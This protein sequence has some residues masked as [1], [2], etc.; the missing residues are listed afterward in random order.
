LWAYLQVHYFVSADQHNIH[1]LTIGRALWT[2]NVLRFAWALISEQTE[3]AKAIALCRLLL[4]C[5]TQPTFSCTS[6]ATAPDITTEMIGPIISDDDFEDHPPH[7][8][9]ETKGYQGPSD[10]YTIKNKQH[11]YPIAHQPEFHIRVETIEKK[12]SELDRTSRRPTGNQQLVRIVVEPFGFRKYE[13]VNSFSSI[14]NQLYN[15]KLADYFI[16]DHVTVLPMWTRVIHHDRETTNNNVELN[17]RILKT[18]D[19]AMK[20]LPVSI[21]GKF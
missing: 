2:Q 8:I 9:V 14:K 16:Q 18:N 20:N 11:I 15:T 5:L 4:F 3:V 12:F 13:L 17:F 7:T 21:P 6:S 1:I 19:F 10:K